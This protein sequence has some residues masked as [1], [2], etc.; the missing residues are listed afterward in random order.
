MTTSHDAEFIYYFWGFRCCKDAEGA[1]PWTLD[2]RYANETGPRPVPAPKVEPKDH[3]AEFAAPPNAP[4]PS[5]TKFG[6][7][8]KK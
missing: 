2:T 3:F 4:G 5:K 7:D 6:G 8:Q 1:T